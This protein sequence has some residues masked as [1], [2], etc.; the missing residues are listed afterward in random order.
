MTT[1]LTGLAM[2]LY[3]RDLKQLRVRRLMP[4]DRWLAAV[5][6]TDW[7]YYALL[8]TIFGLLGFVA[9]VYLPNNFNSMTYHLPKV[10]HWAQNH[11]VGV[12]ATWIQRQVQ[13]QPMAEYLLLNFYL[14]S[15]TDRLFNFVQLGSLAICALGVSQ[16]T[17]WLGGSRFLQRSAVLFCLSIPLAIMQATSTQNDLVAAS[18]LVCFVY[19]SLHLAD[20][21]EAA[22]LAPTAVALGLAMI[23]KAYTYVYALPFVIYAGVSSGQADQVTRFPLRWRHRVDRPGLQSA[24]LRPHASHLRQHHRPLRRLPQ[25]GRRVGCGGIQRHPQYGAELCA[26]Q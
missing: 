3:W 24:A 20:K 12:Y 5:S 16:L 23:T 17:A 15:K 18:F 11:S 10:M 26:N 21:A 14:L 1:L 9:A 8:A 25:P 19:F 2:K 13:L 4:L 22:W 7:L 6:L